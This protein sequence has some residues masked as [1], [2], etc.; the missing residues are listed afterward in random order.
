M[1]D[2]RSGHKAECSNSSRREHGLVAFHSR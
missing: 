1:Q 2:V